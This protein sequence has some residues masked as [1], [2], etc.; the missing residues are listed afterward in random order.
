MEKM[1]KR[2]KMIVNHF[3]VNNVFHFIWNKFFDS[4]E[5]ASPNLKMSCFDTMVRSANSHWSGNLRNK[6]SFEPFDE[7][8]KAA[9]QSSSLQLLTHKHH[10]LLLEEMMLLDEGSVF[11]CAISLKHYL[12]QQSRPTSAVEKAPNSHL[13]P[14]ASSFR[15]RFP[16]LSHCINGRQRRCR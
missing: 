2:Q 14:H 9:L 6:H 1:Q 13:Q 10:Q 12:L 16:T 7:T 3:A 15:L 11:M 5:A 8:M 4:M